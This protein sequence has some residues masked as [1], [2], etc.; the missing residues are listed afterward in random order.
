M[1]T[2]DAPPDPF[3]MGRLEGLEDGAANPLTEEQQRHVRTMLRQAEAETPP[4]TRRKAS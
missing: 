3:E 4:A 2:P 1:T